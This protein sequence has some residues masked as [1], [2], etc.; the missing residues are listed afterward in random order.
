ML[1]ALRTRE[2]EIPL[3]F[4]FTTAETEN[5]PKE[6]VLEE[7]WRGSIWPRPH[8]GLAEEKGRSSLR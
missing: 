8:Q 1:F 3:F 7:S 2:E 6:R 4:V 5:V